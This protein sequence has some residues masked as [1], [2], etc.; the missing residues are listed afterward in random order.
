M[1][2][3]IHDIQLQTRAC[4]T[5]VTHVFYPENT[6]NTLYSETV[7]IL[8]TLEALFVVM[9]DHNTNILNI[10]TADKFGAR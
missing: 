8:M 1:N 2:K 5:R 6:F 7:Y 3:H 4:M 10:L 9:T